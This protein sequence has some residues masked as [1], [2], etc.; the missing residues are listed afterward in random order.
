MD[1][2]IERLLHGVRY[3]HLLESRI[4]FIREK[5]NLRR[6]DVEILYYL[7]SCG[8]KNTP[9]DIT[10]R[11]VLTKSHISQSV[12]SLQKRGLL[13]SIPDA[14]DRRCI[15]LKL[16]GQAETVVKDI[17]KAWTDLNQIVFAGITQEEMELLRQVAARIGE[18]MDRALQQLQE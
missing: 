10:T 7:S 9:T 2:Q 11:S 3:K 15:H 17:N 18:N 13:E 1:T 8:E 14:D 4:A 5:Y 6:A 16:T 12:D